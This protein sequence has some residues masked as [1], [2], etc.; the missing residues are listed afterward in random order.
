MC[1][2]TSAVRPYQQWHW[3]GDEIVHRAVI[4][5]A[6]RPPGSRKRGYDVDIRGFLSIENNQVIREWLQASLDALDP[7]DQ[8]FFHGRTPGSFDF[9]AHVAVASM[10]RLRYVKGKRELDQWLYPEETLFLKGGDCEDL[11]FVLA[12]LLAAA[13]IS[14]DC[15][16]VALGSIVDHSDPE[17]IESWDHAWVMYLTE[18]GAWQL[19]E[20]LSKIS[21]RGSADGLSGSGDSAAGRDIEYVPHFVFNTNHL[22]RV[23]SPQLIAASR[24]DDYLEARAENFWAE[25]DPRFAAGVHNDIFDQ[26]L[27]G[28]RPSELVVVKAASLAVDANVLAYDPRDH[29]DF[30]YIGEGWH[31]VQT[32]LTT[33]SL[34]DFALAAHAIGDFYAHSLYG[35]FAA[36]NGALPI[37][38]PSTGFP[39]DSLNYEFLKFEPRP[40]PRQSDDTFAERWKGKIISGQWWRWYTTYPKELRGDKDAELNYHRC[41]PDHDRLAVDGPNLDLTVGHALF[42]SSEEYR[43]QFGVR[44]A[45][46]VEHLRRTYKEWRQMH[47][48]GP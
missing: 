35:Y 21:H 7:M 6:R 42:K 23:R 47:R 14:K 31:R 8:L 39:P 12:A 16:R 17:R 41:L 15:I 24:F 19:L 22:W 27:V 36:Q 30:A 40:G 28:M 11:A 18:G 3:A 38:D 46:A 4:P 13:G 2:Q 45:A 5:A 9:R 43:H 25:F 29:F 37:Y 44:K 33:G 32:R 48:T 26:A 20:P 34:S 10:G 1:M